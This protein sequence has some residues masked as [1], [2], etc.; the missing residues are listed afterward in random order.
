MRVIFMGTP[1]FALPALRALI[2]STHHEVVAVY[3]QPPRPAGRGQ[4]LTPSPVHQLAEAH[5]IA[6]HTPL[7]LKPAEAQATFATHCADVAVVAAYGLLLPQAILDAPARGC[8]NIHP[9]DLPRWRGA[10][11]IQRTLMAGDSHTACCIMQMNAGLD[12]GDI[13]LRE[14]YIIPPDMDAGGLHDAMAELGA[15]LTLRLLNAPAWPK[16][17]KQSEQ[18]VTYAAKLTKADTMLDWAQPAHTLQHQIRG[19][20]P[21]M[22]GVTILAGE[23]LKIFA[24]SLGEGDRTKPA[25]MVLDNA[26]RI[27]CG[28]GK[29]LAPTLVQRA[30]KPRLSTQAFLQGNPVAQGT[31]LEKPQ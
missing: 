9:S 27:N 6:L 22:G 28:D 31:L 20:S 19:L 8:V 14:A 1:A 11:P 29:S 12:T 4:K 30:G 23:P 10:A 21:S 17:V 5:G 18:G 24:A 15:A 26:L 7:S 16:A 13:L 2:A 25:G 3:S